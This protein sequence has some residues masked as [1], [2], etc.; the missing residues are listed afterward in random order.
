MSAHALRVQDL[1][2]HRGWLYRLAVDIVRDADLARDLVQETCVAALKAAPPDADKVQP[3]LAGVLRNLARMN[4]RTA[5]RRRGR[6]HAWIE[7]DGAAPS[8][9]QLLDRAEA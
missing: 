4:A 2:A 1:L 5:I 7:E 9:E 3:W 8:P 6:E